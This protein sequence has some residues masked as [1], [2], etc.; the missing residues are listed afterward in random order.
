MLRKSFLWL[1]LSGLADVA[2]ASQP[3]VS[4]LDAVPAG[5]VPVTA[6]AGGRVVRSGEAGMAYQWPGAYFEAAFEGDGIVFAHGEGDV[7]LHVLV[8]GQRIDTLDKPLGAYR[9]AG[10]SPGRHVVRVEVATES[11]AGANRFDGFSLPAAME[12]LPMPVRARRMEF[13]GDSHTVGYANLSTHR[14]C[15]DAEV[16]RTT[17]NT[18]AFGALVA[19]HYGADYRVH[20]ISGRGVVRNYDGG[21][22]DTLPEAYPYALLG[23]SAT[24]DD[25]G[26]Q[27]QVVVMALGTNDFSTPLREGERWGGRAALQDDYVQTY[28]SFIR[29]LHARY[30]DARFVLW[31]TD[32]AEGEIRAQVPRVV[33]RLREAGGIEVDFVPVDGLA[34]DACHWHPSVADDSLIAERL[35]RHLDVMA[36]WPWPAQATP[37]A[38]P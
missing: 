16:W 3:T 32:G 18:R 6:V 28:V 15:D 19:R 11:Q 31:A 12:A 10:L 26:W 13:I 23:R 4:A 20:A 37:T 8:D 5:H 35:I 7:I 24:T 22:G 25:T 33:E 1:A 38:M 30:P 29:S 2:G 21:A 34:M 14:E 9:I 27:P 17:D 36:D